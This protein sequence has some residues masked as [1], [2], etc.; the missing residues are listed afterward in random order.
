M[1]TPRVATHL[2]VRKRCELT[3][4]VDLARHDFRGYGSAEKSGTRVTSV[5]QYGRL[6]SRRFFT[7]ASHSDGL[8]MAGP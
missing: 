7:P 3:A 6:E 5:V 2:H 8:Y 1:L 4:V